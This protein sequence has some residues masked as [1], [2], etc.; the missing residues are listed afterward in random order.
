MICWNFSLIF[1][2]NSVES[3]F[4]RIND[5]YCKLCWSME[6]IFSREKYQIFWPSILTDFSNNSYFP[7]SEWRLFD[8]NISIF[9]TCQLFPQLIYNHRQIQVLRVLNFDICNFK[10]LLF[11]LRSTWMPKMCPQKKRIDVIDFLLKIPV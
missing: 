11:N 7:V 10:F 8:F 3:Q 1:K 2:L 9:S 6:Q 4:V 5:F